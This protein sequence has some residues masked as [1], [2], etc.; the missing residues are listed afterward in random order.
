MSAWWKAVGINYIRYSSVT[1]NVLR[2]VVKPDM[3]KAALARG[4][5]NIMIAK[6][7]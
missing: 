1:S 7:L 3:Q 2:N 6:K 4:Q 5:M